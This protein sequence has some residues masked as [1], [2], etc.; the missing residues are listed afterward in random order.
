MFNIRFCHVCLFHLLPT[1][2]YIRNHMLNI[3]GTIISLNVRN[4]NYV[5]H[6]FDSN[7]TC[8]AHTEV[9]IRVFSDGKSLIHEF[10]NIAWL[11]AWLYAYLH[12]ISHLE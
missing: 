12:R 5:S 3:C 10:G 7:F 6:I 1:F 9:Y 2:T 4:V 11:Y 8:I